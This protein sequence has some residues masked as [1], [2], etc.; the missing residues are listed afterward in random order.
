MYVNVV[1]PYRASP[2]RLRLALDGCAVALHGCSSP[3]HSSPC[4]LDS[5]VNSNVSKPP[6]SGLEQSPGEHH[7]A[8]AQVG[9]PAEA[10]VPKA[11]PQARRLVPRHDLGRARFKGQ[12]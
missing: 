10:R 11:A 7:G 9:G 8:A 5:T 1:S 3:S 12:G 6:G 2:V 4:S